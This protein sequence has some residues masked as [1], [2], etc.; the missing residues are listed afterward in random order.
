MNRLSV[1]E[2]RVAACRSII[3]FID[4]NDPGLTHNLGTADSLCYVLID[5]IVHL[6]AIGSP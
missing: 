6:N 2:F 1:P 4:L 5:I 3:E